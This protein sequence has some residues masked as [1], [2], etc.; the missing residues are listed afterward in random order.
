[1]PGP[2]ELAAFSRELEDLGYFSLGFPDRYFVGG[3]PE[4]IPLYEPFAAL[5][6][7]GAV[8]SRLRLVCIV[9][10]NDFRHPAHYARSVAS[11]DVLSEGRVEAGIGA[12]WFGPEFEAIGIPFDTPG[13][14]IDRLERGDRSHQ[15]F[16]DQR[17]D[18]LFR[19]ALPDFGGAGFAAANPATASAS[20]NRRRGAADAGTCRP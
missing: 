6:Y 7:V 15:E 11:L 10:A 8:T 2:I 20:A 14:R 3:G 16:V 18:G 19:Q 13:E 1:M 17:P 9:A 12:G 5:S 4:F